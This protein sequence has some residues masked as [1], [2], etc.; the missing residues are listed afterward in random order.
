MVLF[1]LLGVPEVHTSFVHGLPSTGVS[2]F[3]MA[4]VVPPT[5]LQRSSWQSPAVWLPLGSAVPLA[6]LATPQVLLLQVKV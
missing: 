4:L 6:V 1:G 5:P 2:V 3:R